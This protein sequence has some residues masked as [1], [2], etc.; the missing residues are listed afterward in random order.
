MPESSGMWIVRWWNEL[1]GIRYRCK[2]KDSL[3]QLVLCTKQLTGMNIREEREKSPSPSDAQCCAS[4]WL[5][6]K[7]VFFCV[8]IYDCCSRKIIDIFQ[9][10]KLYYAMNRWTRFVHLQATGD[11]G[12][13]V[14]ESSDVRYIGAE[15]KENSRNIRES[16]VWSRW[17]Y[18]FFECRRQFING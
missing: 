3:G 2:W 8:T 14:G 10:L 16:S 17:L 15:A 6:R 13:N 7:L 1:H 12:K 18:S 11:S 9:Y 5:R 4:E